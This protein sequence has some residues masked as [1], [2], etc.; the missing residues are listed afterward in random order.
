MDYTTIKETC[1]TFNQGFAALGS[2]FML[3][4]S[5]QQRLKKSINKLLTL[6]Q[7]STYPPGYGDTTAGNYIS[8][9]MLIDPKA[10]QQMLNRKDIYLTEKA[11]Q[12]LTFWKDN[13]GFW[14][15]FVIRE[16][17][18]DDFFTIKDLVRGEEHLLYS[19][20]LASLQK[21]ATSRNKQYLCLLLPNGECLQTAGILRHYSLSVEDLMFYCSLFEAE[22]DLQTVITNHYSDF[23]ELDMIS[24]IPTMIHGDHDFVYTWTEF[25]LQEFDIK[26]L[27]GAWKVRTADS[28]IS[29]T[30]EEPDASMMDVPNGN[31]LG[32]DFP[33]MNAII[34]RDEKTGLM[35][36]YTRFK[37]SYAIY[38]ALL[39]R[40]YPDL[41]LDEEPDIAIAMPLYIFLT[42]T[43]LTLPWDTFKEIMDADDEDDE[44]EIS[45]EEK[46]RLDA[47]L[48]EYGNT[49]NAGLA[50]DAE[51]YSKKSGMALDE[52]EEIVQ[53]L[54]EAYDRNVPSYEVSAEDKTYELTDWPVPPP[55]MLTQF[56]DGLETAMLFDYDDGPDT[57][58]LFSL[59]VGE[60]HSD[61]IDVYGLTEYIEGMFDDY[62]DFGI[63]YTLM[64]SFFWILFYKGREAVAVR[65]YAIEMLKLFPYPISQVYPEGEAFIEAFSRFTKKILCSQGI[66]SLAK[67][68]SSEEVRKGTFTIKGSDAF[69]SLTKS[70]DR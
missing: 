54:Q 46:Q 60:A 5:K 70:W 10:M 53:S 2:H 38:K 39:I 55:K 64:N 24:K 22:E 35:A 44:D 59:L 1:K 15:Y 40:A 48:A 68:P 14:S 52:V 16:K 25:T 9:Q 32:T 67:R 12:V 17:L 47:L 49:L 56:H 6:N 28:Q 61:A 18:E 50:F 51:A 45:P 36:L 23:F 20:G 42:R 27:G 4:G 58:K 3:W 41:D 62:F 7:S 29:Y 69:Y 8:A 43:H 31:L 34:Y 63:A 13:P 11:R 30:L 19:P 21:S 57:Q 66:C 26:H 33:M 65:S 37:V